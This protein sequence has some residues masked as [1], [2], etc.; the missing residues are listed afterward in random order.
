MEQKVRFR[1]PNA[2][3]CFV[4]GYENEMGLKSSFYI[5][6]TGDLVATFTPVEEHQSY[7]ERMHGGIAATLLDEA[8]GRAVNQEIDSDLWGVTM[9]FTIKFRKPVPLNTT[10]MALCRLTRETRRSFE[11]VGYILLKDGSIAAEASG[12]YLKMSIDKIAEREPADDEWIFLGE[13]LEY[14][15]V[16]GQFFEDD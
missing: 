15:E 5:L 14:I 4:C 13:D 8:I 7:P 6:E 12:R 9:E 1:Q 16:P 3:M 2:K 10:L 11:G